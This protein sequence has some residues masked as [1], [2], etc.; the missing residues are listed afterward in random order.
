MVLYK[1]L[2]ILEKKASNR[3]LRKFLFNEYYG[4]KDMY[5]AILYTTAFGILAGI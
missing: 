2:G 4:I 1:Y 3:L 5:W